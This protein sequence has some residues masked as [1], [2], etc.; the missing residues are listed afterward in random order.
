MYNRLLIAT[1]LLLA[2]TILS[3]PIAAQLSRIEVLKNEITTATN[4]G[5]R[6]DATIA[7]CDQW[8]SYSPD[9]LYKYASLVKQQAGQLKN[10]RADLLADYYRA[11]YLFQVNK[12]D[13]ALSQ[14]EEV[15]KEYKIAYPY[16]EMYVKLYGL[17]GNILNR[18]ARMNEYM[19]HNFELIKLAEENKDTLG[20]ARG[21]LGIGIVNYKLK[22]YE[23]GLGWYHKA[24]ALMNNPVYKQKLSFI[25]NN[26]GIVHFYMGNSDSAIYYIQQALKYSREAQ[27]LTDHANAL[28]LYGGIMSELNR[29]DE[30]EKGFKEAVEERKKIGDV[31]YIV[32]D[33]GQLAY[34]YANTN[35][36]AK[37]IALCKEAIRLAEENGPMY[38]NMSSLY[39]TLGKNYLAAGDYKNY[40][41]ALLKVLELKDSVYKIN[42][43]EQMAELQ[44]RYDVQRKENI[45]IQQKYD[46]TRKNYFIYG[47]L[48]LLL[49]G[50]VVAWLAF[51]H[52]RQ[53]QK[54]RL[55]QAIDK[56]KKLSVQAIYEAEEN[57]RKR[58]AADLHDNLG[59]QA[60]ALLYGTE[61]LQQ[62]QPGHLV[63]NLQ[64]TAKDMLQSLRETV[65]AMKQTD[66]AIGDVWLRVINFTK[67][68]GMIFNRIKISTEGEVPQR[69][70][71]SSARALHII[72]IIQE[73]IN[74]S[75]RHANASKIT[76]KS[77]AT[78]THWRIEVSDN[79]SGF[80]KEQVKE[81]AQGFGLVNMEERA[82]L[83]DIRLNMDSR[84]GKGTIVFIEVPI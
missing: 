37:G 65:W 52:Y 54:F 67:H 45:I 7:F 2:C 62:V 59:A 57:E 69:Q 41:E 49:L 22:K 15:M 29:L 48:L 33:M 12:L 83:A 63:S 76:V 23:E 47:S 6:L 40:S 77:T 27:N 50:G 32:T 81:H 84:L 79:G 19:A 82:R 24:L 60:N 26:M 74:N 25:F 58:I 28:F 34:F 43:A 4:A 73:A 66:A 10:H 3:Q 71:I 56:E 14:A 42:S 21:T 55:L 64:H 78:D 38:S 16:D 80:E 68:L 61:Q 51:R 70:T 5:K 36:P 30:A 31:Y 39:G 9:T 20:M 53:S 8:E 44:T 1:T 11:A 35:N 46:L 72:L 75:V 13:S 18:T 17:R